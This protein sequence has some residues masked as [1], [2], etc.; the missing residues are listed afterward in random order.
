MFF[1][2][3]SC[4]HSDSWFF[5]S[6]I[7]FNAEN[8]WKQEVKSEWGTL[9]IKWSLQLKML[10]ENDWFMICRKRWKVLCVWS[11]YRWCV[12]PYGTMITM[13]RCT[14]MWY[15]APPYCEKEIW[16]TLALVRI[17][18]TD[19]FNLQT[20]SQRNCCKKIL[21]SIV[22]LVN[23]LKQISGWQKKKNKQKPFYCY[24]HSNKKNKWYKGISV[25]FKNAFS[26]TL[27]N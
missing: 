4:H 6:G 16:L 25:W 13:I 9:S 3:P 27:F 23:L 19:S 17:H 26:R 8:L 12:T 22:H 5:F 1:S 7:K 18:I 15:C 11:L 2:P 14:R 21:G 24:Y 10:Q 20:S